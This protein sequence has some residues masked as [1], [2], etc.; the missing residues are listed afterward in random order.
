VGW[1]LGEGAWPG[2]VVVVVGGTEVTIVV[3]TDFLDQQDKL[4]EKA[5]YSL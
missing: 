1:L 3:V 5:F 2:E 4:V